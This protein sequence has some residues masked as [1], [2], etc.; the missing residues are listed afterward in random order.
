MQLL[1]IVLR[2]DYLKFSAAALNKL[3]QLVNL[4]P[5]SE[6]ITDSSSLSP[7]ISEPE[8]IIYYGLK[9]TDK[10][11]YSDAFDKIAIF[12]E[13][14]CYAINAMFKN[15]F[16]SFQMFGGDSSITSGAL[17]AT[18]NKNIPCYKIRSKRVT[19]VKNTRRE[20]L[21]F[22]YICKINQRSVTHGHNFT[23][24][25]IDYRKHTLFPRTIRFY[26]LGPVPHEHN[27]SP[28]LETETHLKRIDELTQYFNKYNT[29]VIEHFNKLQDVV[30]AGDL[31]IGRSE[32]SFWNGNISYMDFLFYG[33]GHILNS[34]I[35]NF[36][37][38][39]IED[40]IDENKFVVDSFL[41]MRFCGPLWNFIDK[42]YEKITQKRGLELQLIDVTGK[43]M[44]RRNDIVSLTGETF[45][46]FEVK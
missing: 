20:C 33:T 3:L 40:Y 13:S 31:Y 28:L 22:E 11:K 36:Q 39:Y 7:S 26:G 30:F 1:N 15:T 24:M 5:I 27:L 23:M 29:D 4:K 38:I 8:K 32:L 44:E 41:V 16:Y 12:S 17:F 18:T 34:Y 25:F 45:H 43:K 37:K 19:T 9:L 42:L 46:I 21:S 14:I 35:T 6:P 10:D 2:D